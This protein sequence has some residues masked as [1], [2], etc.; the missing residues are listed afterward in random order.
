MQKKG[1]RYALPPILFLALVLISGCTAPNTQDI[2]YSTVTSKAT[3]ASGAAQAPRVLYLNVTGLWCGQCDERVE[4][5]IAAAPG[6][7]SVE[8]TITDRENELGVARVV[9][10]PSL[11]MKEQISA[12]TEPYSSSIVSDRVL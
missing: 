8:V 4:N 9:Y 6:I 10:D 1:M 12:L 3:Q 7:E 11:I 2:D 5:L